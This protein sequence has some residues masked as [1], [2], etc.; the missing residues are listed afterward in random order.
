M[1]VLNIE[2]TV[3]IK[4]KKEGAY[5]IASCPLLDVHSQGR[6][7]KK[8]IENLEEALQLFTETCY[9]MGTLDEVL[10]DAGLHVQK[11]HCRKHSMRNSISIPLCLA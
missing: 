5:F 8:A 4:V 9:E 3:Q 10:K 6:T 2:M 11:R 1:S 7:K